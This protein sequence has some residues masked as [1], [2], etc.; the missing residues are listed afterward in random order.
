MRKGREV[1]VIG[2]GMHPFGKFP[3]KT[4]EDLFVDATLRALKDAEI[5]WRDVQFI[6][7]GC[8]YWSGMPGLRVAACGLSPV[9]A[10]TAAETGNKA[11]IRRGGCP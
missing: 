4:L 7:G 3:E 9:T 2:V 11:R 6:G 5:E 8:T 1:A 10:A